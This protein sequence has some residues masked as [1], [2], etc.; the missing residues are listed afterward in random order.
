[1]QLIHTG[2]IEVCMTTHLL[3]IPT[4]LHCTPTALLCKSNKR[5][6]CLVT[7]YPSLSLDWKAQ[8]AKMGFPFVRVLT[9][10]QGPLQHCFVHTA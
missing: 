3:Q 4:I 9:Q 10:N 6:V 7:F 8:S 1:M 5:M 2:C